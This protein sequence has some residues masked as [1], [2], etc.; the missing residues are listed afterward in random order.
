MLYVRMQMDRLMCSI[1]L[2]MFLILQKRTLYII[3]SFCQIL[4]I[5]QLSD[6]SSIHKMVKTQERALR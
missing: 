6:I 2:E 5:V 1:D 3:L 4:N